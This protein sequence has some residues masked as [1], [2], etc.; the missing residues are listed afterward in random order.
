[1]K[2]VTKYPL[3]VLFLIGMFGTSLGVAQ[4]GL[5]GKFPVEVNDLALHRLAQPGTP[6]IKAGRRFALLA[7]ESG[8]I[9]AW[10]YPLKLCRSFKFS[11]LIA[12]STRPILS[13]NLVA[14]I[15]VFPEA[16]ILTYTYQSFTVKAIYITPIDEP[17]C[18]ILL[19]VDS[20]EPL[21]IICGFLPVLQPMWPAG[22]GGQHARWDNSLKAYIIS[23]PTRKN[24]GIIG[25]PAAS[26]ISYTP[27]HMLSDT[28]NEFKIEIPYPQAVKNSYIPI[29]CTGGKGKR[30]N[31]L[32]NYKN[33][34][35]NAEQLYK[36]NVT[37]Y[38]TL[39][40]NTIVLK[41]PDSK[42]D[43]AF[44]WAKVVYD[45]LMVDNPDLGEGLIAGLGTSGTSGR[46]GFGWFFGGDAYINSFSILSYGAFEHV[47]EA[48]RFTQKWQRADGKMPHELSQAASYINWWE[49]YPYGFIHGDTTPYYIAAMYEYVR[50]SGDVDFIKESWESIALAYEWC[51]STDANDDGLMDNKKAGLGAL[52]YGALIGIETD[53]YLAAVWLRATQAMQNLS[54]IVGNE[55]FGKRASAT[56]K[57]AKET[58][59]RKFWDEDNQLYAYAFNAG[60]QQVK[61]ISPWSA[62]GLFW[63]YGT[64][65][66]SALSLQKLCS[67]ELTTDWGIR[68]ISNRSQHFQPLNYNYGAVWPFITSWVSAALYAHHMPLQGFALLKATSEHT[69]NRA[70]G[71]ITEV[72]SGSLNTALEESVPHQG[73][74]SAGV[75][76]PLVIGM[77]GLDG[78]AL[79][80]EAV[81][82]PQFPGDW[83]NISI[84]NFKVGDATFSFE[85]QKSLGSMAVR[86]RTSNA[87]PFMLKFAPAFAIGTKIS[88][89]TL[90]GESIPF[91]TKTFSQ[92]IQP[93]AFI[94]LKGNSHLIEVNYMPTVELLPI[95]THSKIGD[96]N[97]G[98]KIIHVEKKE[99]KILL[100]VEGIAGKKY[101]LPLKNTKFV[102]EVSGANLKADKLEIVIPDDKSD[103]F[104]YHHITIHLL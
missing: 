82:A 75:V 9:E 66:K 90:D 74:S 55:S 25:S 102:K 42:L 103:G 70:L 45:S 77:L 44:E 62:V 12:G 56:F 39:R 54:E 2:T 52:E 72:I 27:A 53:I 95:V 87:Q 100:R 34:R 68:S 41:T 10:A 30:E 18:I 8:A 47:R 57:R 63:D 99:K 11:F 85:T 59:E 58:F 6:F 61:E 15:D 71:S 21:T 17:G 29:C 69:F 43:L 24:H 19:D 64:P 28:P 36:D 65:E 94:P 98:L 97:R 96:P 83:E 91:E 4:E 50:K 7:D 104:V 40:R 84:E 23:E 73:F 13:E 33:L 22:L 1:M 3:L 14:T 20:A 35:D 5:I 76:L 46:P 38:R 101:S 92:V 93:I 81:F 16:T 88:S 89:I 26:G 48:L 51:L 37:H 67:S 80:K 60:G 79:E 49:D 86:V 31:I 32:K 78:N